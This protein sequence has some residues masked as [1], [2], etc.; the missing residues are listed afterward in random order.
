ME[1]CAVCKQHLLPTDRVETVDGKKV[2]KEVCKRYLEDAQ[3]S[4]NESNDS[5]DLDEVE[6]L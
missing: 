1:K 5:F 4:V 3:S 6:L 2:H